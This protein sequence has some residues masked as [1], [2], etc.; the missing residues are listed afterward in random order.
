MERAKVFQT[1]LGILVSVMLLFSLAAPAAVHAQKIDKLVVSAAGGVWKESAEKNFIPCFEKRT[2]IKVEVMISPSADLLNR[3]RAN[4]TNPP[5]H[6]AMLSELDALRGGREGLLDKITPEKVPNLKDVPE[7]FYRP[8][9]DFAVI[10]NFGAM[11]VMYNNQVIKEPPK[12]WKTLI[13]NIIAGKYGKR[14]SSPAGSYPWGPMF[15]WFVASLYDGKADTAFAKFKAMLPYVVKYWTDPVE[16]LNMFGTKEIDILFYWDGRAMAFIEQGNPWASF[17]IP[18]PNA[19]L[20]AAMLVKAKGAPD[21]AWQ[22][23]DCVLSPEGQLGHSQL[24]KYPIVNQKVVYPDDLKKILTPSSRV[25]APAFNEFI[26][27]VPAWIERW[28]KEIR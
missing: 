17:Y 27:L 10:Q 16:A 28:N 23:I 4:P 25:V 1:V 5:I 21:V 9:N 2:G 8:W 11:G 18:D 24:V 20:S 7:K 6:V 12:D 15:I 13:D 14:I 22:Y 26:D 3:I 19:F